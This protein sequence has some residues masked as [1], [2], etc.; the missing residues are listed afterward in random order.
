MSLVFSSKETHL[1]VFEE[2][3]FICGELLNKGMAKVA[4]NLTQKSLLEYLVFK[5]WELVSLI[6]FALLGDITSPHP[7][8][9]DTYVEYL[10]SLVSLLGSL[11]GKYRSL[12]FLGSS[13]RNQPAGSRAPGQNNLL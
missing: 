10:R 1:T 9:T 5:P 11:T 3:S 4:R 6:N 8:I 12:L 13:N 2:Q 7:D